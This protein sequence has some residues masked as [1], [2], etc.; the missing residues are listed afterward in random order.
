MTSWHPVGTRP[1]A[2]VVCAKKL[3]HAVVTLQCAG[4]FGVEPCRMFCP[5]LGLEALRRSALDFSIGRT[6]PLV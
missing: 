3:L 1:T 4:E 2:I 6:W 5:E